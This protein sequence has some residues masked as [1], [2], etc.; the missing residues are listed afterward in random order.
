[1]KNLI[2]IALLLSSSFAFSNTDQN[3]VETFFENHTASHFK[4]FCQV[5]VSSPNCRTITFFNEKESGLSVD[6]FQIS[7]VAP[8]RPL[9]AT[10]VFIPRADGSNIYDSYIDTSM[11]GS[12]KVAKTVPIE[13]NKLG[14]N[15]SLKM[16]FGELTF[17]ADRAVVTLKD[18]VTQIVYE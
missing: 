3:L 4:V 7:F 10:E 14:E 11:D 1:M 16:P 9:A 13:V 18:G 17:E 5:D 6:A 12:F 2:T 15:L 8:T